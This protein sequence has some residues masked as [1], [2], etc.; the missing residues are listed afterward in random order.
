MS[1][2]GPRPITTAE[3]DRYGESFESY[4]KVKPGITGLW[5]VSGRN[6]TSYSQRVEMD[7]HYAECWTFGMDLRILLKT[8]RAVW[9]GHGAY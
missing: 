1:F 2:V 7:A 9:H 5:Q 6:T 8:F 4:C 3:I